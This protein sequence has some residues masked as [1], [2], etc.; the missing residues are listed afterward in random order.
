MIYLKTWLI[1]ILVSCYIPTR[2]LSTPAICVRQDGQV[3]I[4]VE[5]V[6]KH[7]L[8]YAKCRQ[9]KMRESL[10]RSKQILQNACKKISLKPEKSTRG[11]PLFT[12]HHKTRHTFCSSSDTLVC[13]RLTVSSS[14]DI[15]VCDDFS[16]SCVARKA[17]SNCAILFCCAG[18]A[19]EGAGVNFCANVNVPQKMHSCIP[20]VS[21]YSRLRVPTMETLA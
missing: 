7:V 1:R 21:K 15:L 17:S 11:T 20:Q 5:G 10:S 3:V 9:G 14:S 4:F 19:P 13:K 8:Q 18:S 2:I 16:I 6:V 12:L